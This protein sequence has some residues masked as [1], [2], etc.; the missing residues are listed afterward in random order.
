MR[1]LIFSANIRTSIRTQRTAAPFKRISQH[2]DG[3]SL[4]KYIKF[5]KLSTFLTKSIVKT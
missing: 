3:K 2:F 1:V 5:K 4:I